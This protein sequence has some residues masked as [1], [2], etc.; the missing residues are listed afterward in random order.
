MTS[1]IV[2]ISQIVQHMKPTDTHRQYVDMS[3]KIITFIG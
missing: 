1:H 2:T 3:R